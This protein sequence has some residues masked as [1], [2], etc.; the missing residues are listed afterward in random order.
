MTMLNLRP[1]AGRVVAP[2]ARTLL[3]IGVTPDMVTVAGTIGAVAGSMR[4][5]ASWASDGDAVSVTAQTAPIKP[6][7]REMLNASPL[8]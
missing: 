4:A 2:L 8:E 5:A 6:N 1:A 7:A 3:R